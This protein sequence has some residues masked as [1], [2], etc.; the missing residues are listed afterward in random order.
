MRGDDE[1]VGADER[2]APLQVGTKL[3][4][5]RG[6]FVGHGE[7]FDVGQEGI[8]GGGV[9]VAVRRDFD[10]VEQFG[11]RDGDRLQALPD[12]PTPWSV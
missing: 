3:R 4:V 10:A 6:H 5:D 7:R 8:N 11:F 9:L 12:R 2:L 1:I